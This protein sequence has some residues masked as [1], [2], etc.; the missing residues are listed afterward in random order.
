MV[1]RER[2]TEEGDCLPVCPQHPHN[3][4]GHL[5]LGCGGGV[6]FLKGGGVSVRTKNLDPLPWNTIIVCKWRPR[7]KHVRRK[8]LQCGGRYESEHTKR[9]MHF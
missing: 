3:T 1:E 6:C 9:K 4:E 7:R 8:G 2:Q 5:A